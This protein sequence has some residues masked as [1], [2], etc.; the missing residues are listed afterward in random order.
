V[1]G[2]STALSVLGDDDGGEASLTYTWAAT[3]TPP[4]GVAFSANGTNAAKNTTATFTKAGGYT[5]QVTVRDP[6]G[7]TVTSSVAVTVDQSLT[8]IAVTP[9]SATINVLTT[10]Q[11]TAVARDQFAAALATQPTFEWTVS[12]GGTVS[13]TGLFTA[14]A[15]GGGPFV[16]TATS[17]ISGTAQ[18]TVTVPNAAPTVATPASA[19]PSPVTGATTT[20]SVLGADDGGEANLTYTWATT[21]TPPAAVSFSANGTNA[22]KT[23]TATFSKAGA[24]S[25]QVTIRDQS[26]LTVTSTVAVTVNQTLTSIVVS[27][28]SATV[29]VSATQQFT[30]T[31]RDQFTTNLTT[32]PSFTWT[33][34]GGGTINASG[35]FTAGSTA[36]GP[37]TVTA[38][39]GAVNGTASVTVAGGGS[40]CTG[41]CT[42]P[43]VFTTQNYQSG[44]LGTGAT[45]HQTTV[46]LAGGNC[47]NISSRTLKVNG[48]TMN[49]NSWTLPAKVNGGYCIQVTAGTPSY[50]TFATW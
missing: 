40:P 20:L 19:L 46:N 8:S 5:L 28:S 24:Y 4:A 11:F 35:V 23:T 38:T 3:G 45:C 2:T 36:G 25:F 27:P 12:G 13:S 49:C 21:G 1:T 18:V 34:S 37:Y 30:A 29:N 9:S 42:S 47:S 16:V 32:Q 43:V 44:N 6:Q 15:T 39:S 33:V 7:A 50:T 26:A 10:Q 22:A 41:L 48:T 14:G 17:G 31:A